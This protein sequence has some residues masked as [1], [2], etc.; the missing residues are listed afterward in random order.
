[1]GAVRITGQRRDEAANRGGLFLLV[2][3]LGLELLLLL[4]DRLILNQSWSDCRVLLFRQ[5][6]P[7]LRHLYQGIAPFPGC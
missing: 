1:M 2:V 6:Q 3:V 4:H 5:A 7:D